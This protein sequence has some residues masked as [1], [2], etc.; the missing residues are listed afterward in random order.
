MI[1]FQCSKKKFGISVL[2]LGY[3]L[4]FGTCLLVLF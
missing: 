1:K 2:E 4:K 3:Y